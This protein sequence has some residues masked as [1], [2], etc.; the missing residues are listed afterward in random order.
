MK[1]KWFKRFGIAFGVL[2]LIILAANF[3]V[4]FWLKNQLPSYLKKN[5]DYVINYK[6]LEVD[7]GTGNIFVSGISINNKQPNNSK[8]IRIQGTVDTLRIN[9]IGIVS[10]LFSKELSTD[11]IYLTNP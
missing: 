10:Y 8:I 1:S 2:F 11:Y 4:N 5:T 9:R 6:N 3:A 7:L